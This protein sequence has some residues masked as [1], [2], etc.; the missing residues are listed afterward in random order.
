MTDVLVEQQDKVLFITLNR[1]EKHNAFDQV[2]LTDLQAALDNSAA[3]PSIR[4]LVLRANGKHFSAGA[5]LAW[6]QRMANF[7]E[8]E[9]RADAMV[10][11]K[12]MYTLHHYPKPTIAMVQGAAF[13]GGAGLIAAC[14]IAIAAQSARFCF[15]ETKLGLIPA[16][17]SPYVIKAIGARAANWLFISAETFDVPRAL[18]LQLIQHAVADEALITFTQ[19]YAEQLARLA[20]EA[21]AA[22]KCLVRDVAYQAM[23]PELMAS[24]ADKIAKK[25]VSQ[26]GQHGLRAFLNKQQPNWDY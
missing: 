4:V 14:D 11:A 13:G 7:S 18:A 17:I 8:A 19:D 24:T 3:D 1:V 25:R 16:V 22:C 5:D 21:M 23:T 15:S 6:M 2:L 9:N 10:L 12:L 20:P 26:E